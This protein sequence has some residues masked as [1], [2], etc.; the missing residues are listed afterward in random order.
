MLERLEHT[1]N[2]DVRLRSNDVDDAKAPDDADA[3]ADGLDGEADARHPEARPSFDIAC[4]SASRVVV[5]RLELE[6][7]RASGG[8]NLVAFARLKLAIAAVVLARTSCSA[9]TAHRRRAA[10][11][12]EVRADPRISPP[13]PARRRAVSRR[14]ISSGVTRDATWTR[15]ARCSRSS[16]SVYAGLQGLQGP[17]ELRCLVLDIDEGRWSGVRRAATRMASCPPRP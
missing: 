12:A 2:D 5:R 6:S 13:A 3:A 8:V 15:V 1:Q 14:W 11:G 16:A 7:S 10:I 9:A 17:R 4:R